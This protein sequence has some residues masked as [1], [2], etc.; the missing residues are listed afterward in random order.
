L[1]NLFFLLTDSATKLFNLVINDPTASDINISQGN[2]A[3]YAKSGEIFNNHLNANL[4]RN[5]PMKKW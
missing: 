3:T 5:L 2:V 1:P 4:P